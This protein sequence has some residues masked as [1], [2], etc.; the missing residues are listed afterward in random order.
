MIVNLFFL[1]I[2]FIFASCKINQSENSNSNQDLHDKIYNELLSAN[3]PTSLAKYSNFGN[4]NVISENLTLC[5]DKSSK[6]DFVNIKVLNAQLNDLPSM[7]SLLGLSK[8]ETCE[9]AY[10]FL[11]KKYEILESHPSVEMLNEKINANNSPLTK[12]KIRLGTDTNSK[13]KVEILNTT[14]YCSGTLINSR[15]LVTA[16]HCIAE[17]LY[18]SG[19]QSYSGIDWVKVKY[20]DPNDDSPE[21]WTLGIEDMNVILCPTYSSGTDAQSDIGIIIKNTPWGTNSDDYMKMWVGTMGNA[22][23]TIIYGSGYDSY[24]GNGDGVMRRGNEYVD[25]YGTYHIYATENGQMQACNGD[26]GGPWVR[27][28]DPWIYVT[29][30]HSNSSLNYPG[31][32]CTGSG[33]RMRACRISAKLGWISS[34]LQSYNAGSCSTSGDYGQCF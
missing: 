30:V 3:T 24:A 8:I 34:V 16:G 2:V 29:G 14:A 28:G 32:K 31:Q 27:D 6:K 10:L 13:G 18:Y 12:S 20:F 33:K 1:L 26:S 17:L 5:I 25:W 9:S 4:M 19:S 21:T 11:E 15:A 23:H 22:R 7:K